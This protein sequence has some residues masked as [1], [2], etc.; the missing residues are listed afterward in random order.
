MNRKNTITLTESELHEIVKESVYNILRQQPNVNEGWMKN[1]ALAGLMALS[2]YNSNAHQ[3]VTPSNSTQMTQ[4]YSQNNKGSMTREEI[5]SILSTWNRMS[6]PAI[7]KG[8]FESM[9]N[10]IISNRQYDEMTANL[11]QGI[12][13]CIIRNEQ[14]KDINSNSFT[15]HDIEYMYGKYGEKGVCI[16]NIEGT[17][18]FFDFNKLMEFVNNYDF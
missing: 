2:P 13:G 6:H 15:A 4:T 8:K 14:G 16:L 18:Y 12:F 17:K 7:E 1:A 10:S 11:R 5:K 3:S 9:L